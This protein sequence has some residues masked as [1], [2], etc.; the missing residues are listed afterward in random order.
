MK[1][2]ILQVAVAITA[3]SF[4]QM[5]SAQADQNL[6]FYDSL[7]CKGTVVSPVPR[8]LHRSYHQIL[9]KLTAYK[10]KRR[11][12]TFANTLVVETD[13][14]APGVT[15]NVET[16]EFGEVRY[17]PSLELDPV[18]FDVIHNNIDGRG[19]KFTYSFFGSLV[20]EDGSI[21]ESGTGTLTVNRSVA[22]A[23]R[24]ELSC[25]GKKI[26]EPTKIIDNTVS[27]PQP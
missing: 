3:S 26:S 6:A 25:G 20:N 13:Y 16:A 23:H 24:Y 14:A 17:R 4:G 7:V 10:S 2:K 19:S 27:R 21:E 18:S 8:G 5:G 12:G 1:S 11:N 15:M 22:G 9:M